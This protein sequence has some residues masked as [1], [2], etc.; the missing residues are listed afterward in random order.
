MLKSER[1]LYFSNLLTKL[2]A[3]KSKD[4]DALRTI[5]ISKYP[6]ERAAA[7]LAVQYYNKFIK[8]SDPNTTLEE[9]NLNPPLP[10]T[11]EELKK[12]I[13]EATEASQA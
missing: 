3:T 8:T 11:F 1:Q 9:G 5:F 4:L 6:G 10:P 12:L 7:G 13:Q 2:A